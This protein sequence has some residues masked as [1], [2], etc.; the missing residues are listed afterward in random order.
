MKNSIVLF[1]SL[2]FLFSSCNDSSDDLSTNSMFDKGIVVLK[3]R[4]PNVPW[5]PSEY[6]SKAILE[7]K[8]ISPRHTSISFR[9][10]LGYSFKDNIYPFEDTRNLGNPV[11]DI[12]KLS[13][14]S[15]SRVS[16]WANNTGEASS[17]SY[18]SFNRYSANSRITKNVNGGF[19]LNLGLFSIGSKTSY[20]EVFTNSLVNNENT[21]FGELNI[22]V[23]DS[24]HRLQISSYIKEQIREKYLLQEFKD[25]LYNTHPSEFFRNYGGFVLSNYVI[26]GKV[27]ALY[28]GTYKKVET[29]ETKEKNMNTEINASY[30]FSYKKDNAGKVSGDLGLGRGNSSSVS[31][32]NEFTSISMSIKTIGGNSS[33]ASFSIPKEINNTD[34][35]LSK[36]LTSLNDKDNQSLVEFG[37][38]GLVPVTDLIVEENLKSQI[39]KYYASG[40]T[41]IQRLTEPYITIDLVAYSY[42]QIY[43]LATHLNTRFGNKI[44]LKSKFM[45]PMKPDTFEGIL[46]KYLKDEAERVSNIFNIKVIS[47]QNSMYAQ[48]P[49][50]QTYYDYDGFNESYLKKYIHDG[51]I[52]IISDYVIEMQSHPRYG[53]KYALSIHKD[54]FIDEYVMRSFVNR[55][56]TISMDY[57]AFLRNYVID[58]L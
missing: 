53:K 15:P 30:G 7:T 47:T 1:A 29:D 8:A 13:K 24:C 28:A 57:E 9:D 36:W 16:S 5:S 52:Y 48:N 44:V 26:G 6:K 10:Y 23:R 50:P 46:N 39:N 25:E 35:D 51:T 19:N 27:T 37:I 3:E 2:L 34:V 54:R 17:F 11:I 4:D 55:L 14:D 58:A 41:T 33:F 12:N 56:P 21:T 43:V 38:D 31:I 18:S 20:S 40:V 45:G 49:Q 22:V 42:P 32:T